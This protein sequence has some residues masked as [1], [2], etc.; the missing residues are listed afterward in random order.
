MCVM[1]CDLEWDAYEVT[2]VVWDRVL[3]CSSG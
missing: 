3:L 1:C 2:F